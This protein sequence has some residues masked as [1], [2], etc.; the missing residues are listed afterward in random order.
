ME[1]NSHVSSV[2]RRLH[3][4]E[5]PESDIRTSKNVKDHGESTDA[6]SESISSF[7]K[8]VVNDGSMNRN[9]LQ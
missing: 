7:A 9:F 5:S 8:T 4:D 6:V 3:L 2:Q 1:Q